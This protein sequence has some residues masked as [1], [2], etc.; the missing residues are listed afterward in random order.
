M[1]SGCGDCLAYF[2]AA[3]V[4]G[5]TFAR[6]SEQRMMKAQARCCLVVACVAV[7]A[8]CLTQQAESEDST[9]VVIHPEGL[10]NPTQRQPHPQLLDDGN[11]IVQSDWPPRTRHLRQHSQPPLA[12]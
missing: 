4:V 9:T 11:P 8:F 1:F 6:Q 10:Q 5:K 2:F 3:F 7:T 12:E